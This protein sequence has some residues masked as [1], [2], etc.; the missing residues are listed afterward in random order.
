ML[1][2]IGILEMAIISAWTKTVSEEK[3]LLSGIITFGNIFVWYYVLQTLLNDLSNWQ[4]IFWYALGCTTGTM[5][6][7]SIF[8]YLKKKQ[9]ANKNL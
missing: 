6:V 2:L 9:V 3:I 7:T 8:N 4:L 5:L 1:F